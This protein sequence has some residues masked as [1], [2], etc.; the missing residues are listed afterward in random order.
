M[1]GGLW[2]Q[3]GQQ[4]GGRRRVVRTAGTVL[5]AGIPLGLA[6]ARLLGRR[7]RSGAEGTDQPRS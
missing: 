4:R 6:A 7:R 2:H 3:P 1:D 5:G